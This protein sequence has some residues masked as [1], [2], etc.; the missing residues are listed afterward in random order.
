MKA[1]FDRHGM[2]LLRQPAETVLSPCKTELQFSAGAERLL[3]DP[4]TQQVLLF[5]DDEFRHM[6]AAYGHLYLRDFF[7]RLVEDRAAEFP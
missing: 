4:Q 7:A 5:P 6:N 1:K 2:H 3:P